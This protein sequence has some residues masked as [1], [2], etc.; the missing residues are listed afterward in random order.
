MSSHLVA[1]VEEIAAEAAGRPAIP[2]RPQRRHVLAH[3][4]LDG[5]ARCAAPHVTDPE[6]LALPP[7]TA[8]RVRNDAAAVREIGSCASAGRPHARLG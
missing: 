1:A 7:I 4:P 3:R 2:S 6:G 8:S 5:G